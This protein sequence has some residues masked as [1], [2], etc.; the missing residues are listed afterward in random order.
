MTQ[1][2]FT[3]KIT[4]ALLVLDV[5]ESV[6][7]MEQDQEDFVSRWQQL[8]RQTE[9]ILS[10]YAGRIV[11][12]LG[13]GLMLEFNDEKDCVH[14]A[15][16]LQRLTL[17]LNV[18]RRLLQQM[19]LRM[20]AHLANFVSD[21]HDIYG[22][23]VNLT[24]RMCSLAG[25]NEIVISAA[26]SARLAHQLDA[27]IEDMGECYLKHVEKPVQL[28]RITPVR[29]LN[30]VV[31]ESTPIKLKPTLAVIPFAPA[32]AG[33]NDTLVADIFVETLLTALSQVSELN[34][35]AP[36][37][38]NKPQLQL[39]TGQKNYFH[40]DYIV[41]SA[42]NRR[43]EQQVMLMIELIETKTGK[44]LWNTVVETNEY[45]LLNGADACFSELVAQLWL[46]I[47]RTELRKISSENITKDSALITD[48]LE[49]NDCD[50]SF[51]RII[52]P[53]CQH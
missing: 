21:Q 33:T 52:Q 27:D 35:I 6:R 15:F 28:F 49:F 53:S 7:L 34:V 38:Q 30:P 50:Q 20:G 18:G 13:D 9:Q 51:K 45:N 8:V 47:T 10:V 24:S 42:V 14:A 46:R 48:T 12:S 11:K 19:H 29:R 40:V 39:Q 2:P 32:I 44:A 1:T 4:K 22:I 23:D 41:V 16:E 36:S 31:V 17:K 25:P 26:L 5:V 43:P 37:I 3:R